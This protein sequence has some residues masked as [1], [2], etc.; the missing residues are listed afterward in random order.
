MLRD[1]SRRH[2]PHPSL[3]GYLITGGRHY[4]NRRGRENISRVAGAQKV[5]AAIDTVGAQHVIVPRKYLYHI[6][7]QPLALE[8]DNYIVVVEW[9][10]ILRHHENNEALWNLDDAR[11]RELLEVL[12][13]VRYPSLHSANICML[14]DRST[15][16]IVDTEEWRHTPSKAYCVGRFQKM[17]DPQT[18][19]RI[20]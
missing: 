8:N 7:L 1:S 12:L 4:A 3:P 14:S 10:P 18:V 13:A 16:A 15:I 20:L 17:V 11:A 2:A 6:P 19:E 9:L 5:Q